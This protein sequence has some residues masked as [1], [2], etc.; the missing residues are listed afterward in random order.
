M[1]DDGIEGDGEKESGVGLRGESLSDTLDAL[2]DEKRRYAL[3]FFQNQTK[4]VASVEDLAEYILARE[5]E[6]DDG[7]HVRVALHHRDLPNLDDAGLID[8]DARSN[9]VRYRGDSTA[10]DLLEHLSD[11]G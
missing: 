2:A 6:A 9:T 1:S 8:Y 7:D 4:D 3:H 10:E 5:C 11:R